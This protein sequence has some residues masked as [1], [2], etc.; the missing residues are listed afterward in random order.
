MKTLVGLCIAERTSS[1]RALHY[2]ANNGTKSHMDIEQN[3]VHQHRHNDPIN[4]L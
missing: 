1:A 4:T 2:N 3:V